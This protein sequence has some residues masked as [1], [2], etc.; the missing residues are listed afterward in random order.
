MQCIYQAEGRVH[1]EEGR[2]LSGSAA[3]IEHFTSCMAAVNF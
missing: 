3:G 1:P 2:E